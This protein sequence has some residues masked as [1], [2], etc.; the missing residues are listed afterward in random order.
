M[1]GGSWVTHDL[2]AFSDKLKRRA[3]LHTCMKRPVCGC[4]QLLDYMDALQ[5]TTYS[6]SLAQP[7]LKP[8]VLFKG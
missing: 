3:C 6:M 8:M 4:R 7:C 2:G 1:E 5:P